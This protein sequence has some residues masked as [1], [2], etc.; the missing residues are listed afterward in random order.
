[1]LDRFSYFFAENLHWKTI[2]M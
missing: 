2:Y 1:M